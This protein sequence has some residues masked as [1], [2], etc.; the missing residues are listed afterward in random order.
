MA[1]RGSHVAI[2][3]R[4]L[5]LT[6]L[7]A[8]ALLAASSVWSPVHGQARATGV[9]GQTRN[10]Q[11]DGFLL[12]WSASSSKRLPADS[13][14]VY[15]AANT[16]DG[17][18]GYF[19]VTRTGSVQTMLINRVGLPLDSALSIPLTATSAD[20]GVY[21]VSADSGTSAIRVEWLLPWP[22]VGLDSTG[23]Y[24]LAIATAD[25]QKNPL[26]IG[27]IAGTRSTVVAAKPGGVVT[28]RI[29]G[30]AML[31]VVLAALFFYTRSRAV[32]LQR[33]NRDSA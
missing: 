21:R 15:D 23:H 17:L 27:M 19:V 10:I 8:G 3:G 20:S 29:K 12:E 9:V 26:A 25:A 1:R 5:G 14:V 33:K 2:D 16:P 6:R 18:A 22:A 28:P 4:Y 31:I 7:I 24:R 32:K 11:L 30:Q 13:T